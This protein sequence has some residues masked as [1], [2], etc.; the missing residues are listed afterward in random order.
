VQPGTTLYSYAERA[1]WRLPYPSVTTLSYATDF[2]SYHLTNVTRADG[3]RDRVM[4]STGHLGLVPLAGRQPDGDEFGYNPAHASEGRPAFPHGYMDVFVGPAP[5]PAT[6][7]ERWADGV[8]AEAYRPSITNTSVLNEL[9]EPQ[10]G[11]SQIGPPAGWSPEEGGM[12]VSTSVAITYIEWHMYDFSH[13]VFHYTPLPYDERYQIRDA[14]GRWRNVA[15]HAAAIAFVWRDVNGLVRNTVSA[16]RVPVLA[17][18]ADG[19]PAAF[20]DQT[21]SGCIGADVLG[22]SFVQPDRLWSARNGT[23]YRGVLVT[24]PPGALGQALT[25][26]L[27]NLREFYMEPGHWRRGNDALHEV[28]RQIGELVA[29]TGYSQVPGLMSVLGA[30]DFFGRMRSNVERFGVEVLIEYRDNYTGQRDPDRDTRRV[31]NPL[32]TV[33]VNINRREPRPQQLFDLQQQLFGQV[34]EALQGV[35]GDPDLAPLAPPREWLADWA[36][37]GNG[38]GMFRQFGPASMAEIV[39]Q[40]RAGLPTVQAEGARVAFWEQDRLFVSAVRV[41][42]AVG[43]NLATQQIQAGYRVGANEARHLATSSSLRQHGTVMS[44]VVEAAP[45]AQ[46]GQVRGSDRQAD[47]RGVYP[48]GIQADGWLVPRELGNEYHAHNGWRPQCHNRGEEASTSVGH[49]HIDRMCRLRSLAERQCYDEEGEESAGPYSDAVVFSR[50][51]RP[52]W[53]GNA[54]INS[55]IRAEGN[56]QY[57][58]GGKRVT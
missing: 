42:R 25:L 1:M 52:E 38:Q 43:T 13:S 28:Y 26:G 10:N 35:Y 58:E 40:E 56:G 21:A 12:W 31:V 55:G 19:V 7:F 44:L 57:A 49:E 6:Q 54:A 29:H 41:A 4:G 27:L 8:G 16:T 18:F 39:E 37:Q 11:F 22:A 15:G 20:A 51:S 33:V 53:A 5:V 36:Q 32:R 9:G 17:P 45:R 46:R 47:T 48:G 30:F 2:A 34:Q 24:L 23:E 3:S 14:Y 50:S